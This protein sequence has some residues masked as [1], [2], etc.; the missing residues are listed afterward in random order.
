M[1]KAATENLPANQPISYFELEDLYLNDCHETNSSKAK[2]KNLKTTF[3]AWRNSLKVNNDTV[4]GA[5]FQELFLEGDRQDKATTSRTTTQL[6]P[7]LQ[8]SNAS[9]ILGSDKF[10]ICRLPF[11]KIDCSPRIGYSSAPST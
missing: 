7:M 2:I 3:N 8:C 5:E 1:N 11:G 9:P 10:G 4:V 6:S